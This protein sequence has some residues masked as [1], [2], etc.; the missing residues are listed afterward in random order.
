M[1]PDSDYIPCV[2]AKLSSTKDRTFATS[3]AFAAPTGN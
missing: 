3:N 2:E 1:T